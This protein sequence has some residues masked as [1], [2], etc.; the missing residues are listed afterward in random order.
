LMQMQTPDPDPI[1]SLHI[2]ENKN[3][4]KNFIHSSAYLHCFTFFVCVNSLENK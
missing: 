2:L 3:F 1:P 4:L